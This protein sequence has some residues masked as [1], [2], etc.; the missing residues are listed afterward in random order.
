[1]IQTFTDLGIPLVS[2]IQRSLVSVIHQA[3]RQAHGDGDVA[4]TRRQDA[5]SAAAGAAGGRPAEGQVGIKVA[6][7]S[8]KAVADLVDQAVAQS[9]STSSNAADHRGRAVDI[10]V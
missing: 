4:S 9:G 5:P 10:A 7:E 3:L 6:A 1:M 2:H 8:E